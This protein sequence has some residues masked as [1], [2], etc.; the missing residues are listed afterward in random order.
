[1]KYTI[2]T[3]LLG[4]GFIAPAL[5]E[6]KKAT[7]KEKAEAT[8]KHNK[9]T[10]KLSEDQDSVAADV[11]ELVDEQ[12][13]PK[14]IELLTEVETLMAETIDKLDARDTGGETI[15]TQTEIIEK[16]YEAAKEKST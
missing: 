6:E 2:L 10:A 1:M 9:G 14:V 16:I 5:A 3:L 8:E 12:T 15:A 4:A 7:A 11:Q 13:N